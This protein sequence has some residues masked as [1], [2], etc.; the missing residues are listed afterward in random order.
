MLHA[1][2]AP[3]ADFRIKDCRSAWRSDIGNSIYLHNAL[4]IRFQ[5]PIGI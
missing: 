4:L 2:V 3:V 5:I 1:R